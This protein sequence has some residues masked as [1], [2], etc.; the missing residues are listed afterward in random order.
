ME[1]ES[2]S[3]KISFLRPGWWMVHMAAISAVYILGH[4]LWR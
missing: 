2:F 1:R 3:K 4:F